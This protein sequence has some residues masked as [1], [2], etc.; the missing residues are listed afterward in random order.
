MAATTPG[1]AGLNVR[2]TAKGRRATDGR[3]TQLLWRRSLPHG[4]TASAHVFQ[5]GC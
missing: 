1:G 4:L 5:A 3:L 2:L